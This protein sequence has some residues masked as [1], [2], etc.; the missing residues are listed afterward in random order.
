MHA[1]NPQIR[2]TA[3]APFDATYLRFSLTGYPGRLE[4]TRMD[5][6]AF[7]VR[8]GLSRYCSLC[9]FAVP[10][11]VVQVVQAKRRF[12]LSYKKLIKLGIIPVLGP[13]IGQFWVCVGG[14]NYFPA[15]SSRLVAP[16]RFPPR[17]VVCL[18]AAPGGRGSR[19]WSNLL[20]DEPPLRRSR[21]LRRPS[22][23]WSP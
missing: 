10:Y 21:S 17:L 8:R 13:K 18:V 7:T 23:S 2:S 19:S 11:D 14:A 16:G 20:V 15:R 5:A 22:P 1:H 9:T 12:N 3:I 4:Q 6:P